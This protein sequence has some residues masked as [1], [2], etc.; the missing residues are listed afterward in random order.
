MVCW[1]RWVIKRVKTIS[2]VCY[3][4]PIHDPL[5]KRY[6]VYILNAL[7]SELQLFGLL[8]PNQSKCSNFTSF[9][10]MFYILID[11]SWYNPV[12]NLSADVDWCQF[13]QE[14]VLQPSSYITLLGWRG[15]VS[16]I[17]IWKIS[18]L[19]PIYTVRFCRMQPPYDTLTTHFRSQLS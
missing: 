14:L 18:S 19:R 3:C 5:W 9:A 17:H 7:Q 12:L 6:K 11:F 15:G 2:I 8:A 10:L 13:S 16:T 1:P 4:W